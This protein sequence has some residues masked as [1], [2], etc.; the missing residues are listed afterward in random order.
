MDTIEVPGNKS[1]L[2]KVLSELEIGGEISV[3]DILKYRKITETKVAIF[4]L[5]YLD[6][7]EVEWKFSHTRDIEI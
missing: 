3:A 6:G 2:E 4:K 7:E 5:A 1:A